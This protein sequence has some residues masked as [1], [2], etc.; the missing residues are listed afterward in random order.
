MYLGH[1]NSGYA[2]ILGGW[3]VGV[4]HCGKRSEGLGLIAGLTHIDSALWQPKGPAKKGLWCARQGMAASWGR[5]CSTR[6]CTTVASSPVSWGV[7]DT[8]SIRR[9]SDYQSVSRGG[10][11]VLKARGAAE[12]AWFVA[13]RRE[14]WEVPTLKSTASSR[15]TG[16]LVPSLWWPVIGHEEMEWICAKGTGFRPVFRLV[17]NK[18]FFTGRICDY[19]ENLPGNVECG[20][21]SKPARVQGASD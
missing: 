1:E 3:E 19:W 6:H 17:I 12:V 15:R 9:I 4:Q 10:W 5:D 14:D 16:G 18:R 8:Q 2:C 11:K 21:G 7:L 13:W 20:Y